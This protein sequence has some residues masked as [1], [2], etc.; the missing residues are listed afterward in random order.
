VLNVETGGVHN[1]VAFYDADYIRRRARLIQYAIDAR[2]Q[3]W[4]DEEPYRYEPLADEAE[5]YR[6]TP[7]TMEEIRDYNLEDIGI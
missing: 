1:P 3:R 5:R 7:A 2:R 6:W 4:P